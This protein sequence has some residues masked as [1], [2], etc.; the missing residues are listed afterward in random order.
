MSSNPTPTV[1]SAPFVEG[2]REGRLRYQRCCSCGCPQTLQRE[3]C[4]SCGDLQLE[5][6]DASGHGVVHAVTVVWRAP[7]DSFRPLVPYTLVLVTLAEGPRVMG[8]GSPGLQIGQPVVAS[9]FAHDGTN[10]LRFSTP[11]G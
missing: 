3:A 2:L 5:W 7:S 9:Y 1:V 6:K 10:L 4:T 11:T 8:H